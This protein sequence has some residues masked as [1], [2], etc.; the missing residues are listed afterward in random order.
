MPGQPTSDPAPDHE[1]RQDADD[2]PDVGS[3]IDTD[4]VETEADNKAH[5]R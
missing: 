4:K 3:G 1:T 5:K 2:E